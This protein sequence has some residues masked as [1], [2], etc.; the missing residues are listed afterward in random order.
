MLNKFSSL[1]LADLYVE[2]VSLQFSV[3][4]ALVEIAILIW[5]IFLYS[6]ACFELVTP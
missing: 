5:H 3:V 6:K 4:K 1:V 2:L